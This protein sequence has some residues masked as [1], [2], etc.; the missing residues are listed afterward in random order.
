[1]AELLG[2]A[3]DDKM[4]DTAAVV[5]DEEPDFQDLAAIALDNAGIDPQEQL[6]AARTATAA[7]I[8]LPA[9][10]PA[11]VD[12]KEDKIVYELTF[13]LPDAGLA[14]SDGPVIVPMNNDKVAPAEMVVAEGE[15][16]Y[17]T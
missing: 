10:G 14:Q 2:V 9:G 15:R 16:R 4:D 7:L 17:L 3:L 8:S 12:A 6:R 11:I 1:M 13:E 5:E